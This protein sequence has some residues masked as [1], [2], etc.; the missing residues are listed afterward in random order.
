MFE[1]LKVPADLVP[2]DPRFASGPSLVPVEAMEK[3]AQTG[4]HLL[5]TSHRKPQVKALV[6]ET[7][8]GLRKYFE[9]PAD[10]TVVIGNG[11]ATFLFDMIGLGLVQKKSVH[12][13]CGEFSNKWFKSHNLIPWIEAQEISVDLGQGINARA[14]DGADMICTTLNETSTGV[15]ITDLPPKSD[16][17][18]IA[19][20]ATSGA[21]QVKCDISK[22]D[23]FFFS[24]QK[25]FGSEGGLFVC[26]MSPLA[27]ARANEIAADKSRY[28]P[29]IMSWD[30][31]I[32]NSVADQ[33]YNTPAIS[34]F[35]FLNEQVKRMNEFGGYKAVCE[36]AQKRADLIYSWAESKS[37]LSCFIKDRA[38]R[39]T[40]VATIDVDEK[41]PVDDL[42][43]VLRK[44]KIVYDIDAYRGLGRNQFRISL[45]HAIKYDDL[46]KL[47]KLL[48]YAIEQEIK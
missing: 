8:V 25:V 40:S 36:D 42:L 39:S 30:H 13:T 15:Q 4:K 2:S 23:L 24:P 19:V 6:G 38:F 48:S 41:I 31:A 10:Y 35:F 5:G 17:Y 34:T 9:V 22:T 1:N 33:T 11:G 28:I 37:Y 16:K 14:V 12:F 18:L 32:K 27:I 7:L 21:G 47:T 3:L 45:F 29:V 20:D 44:E 46:E 43:K 26:I